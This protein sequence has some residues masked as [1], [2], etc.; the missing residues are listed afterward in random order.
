ML[1]FHGAL[2]EEQRQCPQQGETDEW[3]TARKAACS[4][5][6]GKVCWELHNCEQEVVQ[7]EIAIQSGHAEGQAKV[8]GTH[9]KPAKKEMDLNSK[10]DWF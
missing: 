2:D 9:G 6:A 5:P 10:L 8:A 7:E 3:K 4:Q 1:T